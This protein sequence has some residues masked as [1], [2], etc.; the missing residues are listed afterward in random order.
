M[1][2]P[3]RAVLVVVALLSAAAVPPAR[4]EPPRVVEITA[5]RFGFT[6]SEITVEQG[7]PTT[8]RLR[9]DDVT[10]GFFMKALGIDAI[11]EAGKTTDVVVTP[12]VAGRY[13]VICDHF[14]GAGH[15]DMKM[16]I[17]VR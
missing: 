12:A 2:S 13:T 16:T 8:L 15:G 3:S 1:R 11:I 5:K 14:C 6:P 9:S 7:K 10:H 4:A 17:W